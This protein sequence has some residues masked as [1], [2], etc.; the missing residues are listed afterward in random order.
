MILIVTRNSCFVT[1]MRIGDLRKG[2]IVLWSMFMCNHKLW[3]YS[4]LQAKPNWFIFLFKT[5]PN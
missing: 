1:K 5:W 2:S 4:W 3:E